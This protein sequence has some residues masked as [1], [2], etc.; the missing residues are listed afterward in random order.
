MKLLKH[1]LIFMIFVSA[2]IL[3]FGDG[4]REVAQDQVMVKST[5]YWIYNDLEKGIEQAEK[6]EQPLLVVFR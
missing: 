5:G 3:C 2:A 1:F 6:T 4:D